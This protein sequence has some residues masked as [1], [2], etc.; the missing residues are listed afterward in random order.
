[1]LSTP[2]V[3][4]DFLRFFSV[5]DATSTVTTN[6]NLAMN[7]IRRS[8]MIPTWRDIK[9]TFLFLNTF[10]EFSRSYK[11][12]NIIL[13]LPQDFWGDCPYVRFSVIIFLIPTISKWDY[14]FKSLDSLKKSSTKEKWQSA[15]S[16]LWLIK[17]CVTCLLSHKN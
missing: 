2:K 13:S 12:H 11:K 9:T 8:R 17:L 7:W 15:T 3:V 10:H 1:M 14:I 5:H 16:I 4:A 6:C